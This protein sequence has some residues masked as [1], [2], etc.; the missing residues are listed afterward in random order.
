MDGQMG[1]WMDGQWIDGWIDSVEMEGQMD[2][3]LIVNKWMDS[4]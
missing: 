2:S 3:G 4:G 1:E